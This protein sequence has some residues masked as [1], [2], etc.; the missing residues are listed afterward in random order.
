MVKRCDL[1]FNVYSY[2]TLAEDFI[3]AHSCRHLQTIGK[4][5]NKPYADGVYEINP[6]GKGIVKTICDMTRDGGGWTLLI[7][8][9]TNKWTR[10]NVLQNN[11]MDPKL[12]DDYSILFKADDIKN[13]GNVKGSTFEYRLEADSPGR[14]GGI[15][16]AP[17]SYSFVKTD[18]SQTGVRLTKKFD[19]WGYSWY[20][21]KK[22]MPWLYGER[23]TTAGE[24]KRNEFGSITASMKKYH[25][26][27]WIYGKDK[28]QCPTYIWYWMREGEYG[29]PR[30]CM[31]VMTRSIG[32]EGASDGFYNIQPVDKPVSTYCDMTRNGGG[33]TLLLTSA[34]RQGWNAKNVLER[35][36]QNPS[37]KTDFS[38]LG[39][40]DNILGKEK[41]QYRLEADG[42]DMFGGIWETVRGYSMTSSSDTQTNIRLLKKFGMWDETENLNKRV[43]RLEAG[44]KYLYTTGSARD[45]SG[46][47]VTSAND[48]IYINS[49]KP[50]P[51]V[52]RVWIRE[53]TRRSCN[54]VK[55]YGTQLGI[56]YDDGVYMIKKD[57]VDYLPVFCDMTSDLGAYT[58]LVTSASNNWN[59]KDV[60]FR[61]V[62]KPSLGNDYS[63]L[64]LADNI[65]DIS[66]AKSFKYR[67][68][69]NSPGTWGGIWEAP[70][71]YT[72]LKTDNT[73]TNVN[74]VKKFNQWEY[75]DDGVQKRMPWM[76]GTFGLLT[77]A[78]VGDWYPRGTII[79]D[80][81]E[82]KPANWIYP[83]M[84]DP[85]VI[86][87][88]INE[89]DCDQSRKPVDGGVS[90]WGEWSRCDKLCQ[91]GRMTRQKKCDNPKPKCGGKQCDLKILQ[92]ETKECN[93]CPESPIR[94][95]DK[96]CV[97]PQR[98]SCQI[99]DGT[100]LVYKS[101]AE[102]S[103]EY[104]KFIYDDGILMH[105]CSKKYVCP[106]GGRVDFGAELV[107]VSST[108]NCDPED[109]RFERTPGMSLM[110][111]RSGL[112][113][114]PKG[115]RPSEGVPLVYYEGCD[116]PRLKLDLYQ[117][118]D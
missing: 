114:H 72:F 87:Y 51:K 4:R 42:D 105:K 78:T 55:V 1:L 56:T 86:W 29:P 24:P 65:K 118:K 57:D 89:D 109:A 62:E 49:E 76:A 35:N 85:G 77:T 47:I 33:W 115:G 22:R 37:L 21:L 106:R 54:Q 67:L 75:N 58:L 107:I 23:L 97:Q 40:A 102:C 88:W 92:K 101:S 117:L 82:G 52:I 64:G 45:N 20:G 111:I 100:K 99:P 38:I 13:S 66:A 39:Q 81:R 90:E 94:A 25:P 103:K 10:Q 53:G 34:S 110:H 91:P 50:K 104:Q 96:F 74:L 31:E 70:I 17:R 69:A 14:W 93:Y 27:P 43:P 46:V 16:K 44:G 6:D 5:L 59:A 79:T 63:I 116:Q 7:T 60:T 71:E 98:S 3:E 84:F 30:S 18:N 12:K 83:G 9:Y 11:E 68:E 95:V 32:K 108:G 8:S 48:A 41:F 36:R 113:V 28:E 73:Q 61:N 19:E 80:R 26:A 15:W 112:C 2:E